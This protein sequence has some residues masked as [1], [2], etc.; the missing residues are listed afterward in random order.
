VRGSLVAFGLVVAVGCTRQA[1]ETAPTETAPLPTAGIAGREVPVYPLTLI[2][3]DESLGW[4]EA[5]RPRK[6]ALTRVDSLIGV[7]LTE[8]APEVRWVLPDRLRRAARR[9]PGLLANP[10]QM[11]TALLRGSLKHVPDPLRSQMRT[12]NGMAGGRYALVPA[13][14]YF[15]SEGE[16]RGRAELTL[17]IVDVRT[18][19]LTW[20]SVAQG[21]GD[22]P[23]DAAWQA[24]RS[25]VPGLP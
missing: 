24:L 21:A 20:R 19:L 11:G 23:W 14:L 22:D 15:F 17:V 5:V 2:A 9:A 10:D 1:D 8:S 7:F 13:S 16:G 6:E 4:Q 12:L 25:L 18:G 3:V